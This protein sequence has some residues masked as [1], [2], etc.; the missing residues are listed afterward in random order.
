MFFKSKE[1]NSLRNFPKENYRLGIVE[2]KA[3]KNSNIFFKKIY[4]S[5]NDIS[6][7]INKR[8]A[9]EDI[10]RVLGKKI[11]KN[12]QKDVFYEI[13]IDDMAKIAK[14]FCDIQKSNSI[15]LW[16]GSKRGCKRYHVDIVPFRMLVTYDGQGTEWL[17]DE[18]ANRDAFINGESNDKIVTD[19]SLLQFI[20]K[21]DIAIF[22]GGSNGIIHRTPD[23]ALES[24]SVLMRLDHPQFWENILKYQS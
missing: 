24:S 12:I 20:N 16:L 14:L 2:R 5:L 6:C 4:H 18:A 3:P 1:L 22:R 13:W 11:S 15:G 17:P 9:K 21:W 8:S 10:K 19:R 7:N 23:S